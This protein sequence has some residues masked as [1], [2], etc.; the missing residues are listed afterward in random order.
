MSAS[1]DP[2]R[3]D[4][5]DN[6]DAGRFEGRLQPPDGAPLAVAEYLRVGDTVIFTHTEVPEDLEGEGVG[7]RLV[8]GALERVRAEGLRVRSTCPFVS[9]FLARHPEFRDLMVDVDAKG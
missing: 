4:V 7:S 8:R 1:H 6:P 9:A 2:P 5:R 3:L